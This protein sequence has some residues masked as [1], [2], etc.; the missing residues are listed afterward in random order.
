MN[1]FHSSSLFHLL[2][3]LSLTSNIFDFTLRDSH[4]S[5]NDRARTS[6]IKRKINSLLQSTIFIPHIGGMI[7]ISQEP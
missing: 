6:K 2:D 1:N 3:C 7:S 4:Q 5:A